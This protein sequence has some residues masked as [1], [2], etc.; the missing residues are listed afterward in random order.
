VPRPGVFF[1]IGMG[2]TMF[3]A[4][5]LLVT[6]FLGLVGWRLQL[7]GKRRTELAEEA[8]LAFADAVDA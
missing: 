5:G 6:L 1:S 7:V 8:L 4:L 2:A 3:A